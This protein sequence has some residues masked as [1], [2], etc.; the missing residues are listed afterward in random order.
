MNDVMIDLETL[1]VRPTGAVVSIGA[2]RFDI[3]TPGHTGFRFKANISLDSNVKAGRTISADT[4]EWWFRQSK[5]A[6]K[7]TFPEDKANVC[8]LEQALTHLNTF[9]TADDRVWGN[10]AAFDNAM[11]SD[12]YRSVGIKQQ[13]SYKNDMCYRTMCRLFPEVPR[14]K[15]EAV[16]HDALNDAILQA[17]HLQDIF[18]WMKGDN[19]GET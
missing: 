17:H 7:L 6:Q 18:Q 14:P 19:G 8:T 9:L 2:V 13:W 5:E 3:N 10:G 16:K 15:S 1:D 11:L 4:I 12:A